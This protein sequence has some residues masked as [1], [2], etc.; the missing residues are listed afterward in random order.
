[1]SSG[2]QQAGIST[3]RIR[4]GML[5]RVSINDE[6]LQVS[7]SQPSY[8]AGV[9]ALRAMVAILV[10]YVACGLARVDGTGWLL[11]AYLVAMTSGFVLLERAGVR[12]FGFSQGIWSRRKM[13]YRD[14]F[15]LGRSHT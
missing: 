3:E 14:V 13:V 12:I 15:A 8:R 10:L 1:M 6:Q 7:R 5:A 11:L 4:D 9:W 2:E